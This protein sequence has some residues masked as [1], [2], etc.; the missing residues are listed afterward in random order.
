MEYLIVAYN[1]KASE[2]EYICVLAHT[3]MDVYMYN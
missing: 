2:K 1:A 3:H